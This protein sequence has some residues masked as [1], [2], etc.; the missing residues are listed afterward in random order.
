VRGKEKEDGRL[1][2]G[3]WEWMSDRKEE[4]MEERRSDDELSMWQE[5]GT[6]NTPLPAGASA[7]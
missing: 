4:K 3:K 5:S 7:A 1:R 2:G 6:L